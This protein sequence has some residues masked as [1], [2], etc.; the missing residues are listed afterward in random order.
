MSLPYRVVI[1]DDE[2]WSREVV[3]SLGRWEELGL[4]VVGEA[5]DGPSGLESIRTL[6]PH[7]VIT[8]MRM[9]GM[10][11]TELLQRIAADHPEVRIVVMSGYDEFAYL[12][13]ALQ[14]HAED[15]LLKPIDPDEL[16]RTL[17]RC[18]AGI[19]AP[20]V[21]RPVSMQTALVFSDAELLDEYIVHRQRVFAYLLE[22][23]ALGVERTLVGLE[24]LIGSRTGAEL[25]PDVGERVMHDFIVLLEEFVVRNGLPIDPD[26]FRSGLTSNPTAER[27]PFGAV[28]R[29]YR[30]AIE[31]IAENRRDR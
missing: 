12:R 8:D 24:R 20:Q 22:L 1:L 6:E 10:D 17:E 28:A 15:Y 9:P 18:V 31:Q 2:P 4:R 23:D 3:K 21:G 11:G 7:I 5:D 27:A 19:A 16:N 29:I 13:Q 26:L 14:S 30:R 25:G